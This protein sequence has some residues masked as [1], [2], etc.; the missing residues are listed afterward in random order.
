MSA[1]LYHVTRHIKGVH[2]AATSRRE[3]E[4]K[5]IFQSQLTQYDRCGRGM[6]IIGRCGCNDNN[7]D[8]VRV[9]S[10]FL[11]QKLS[12][13]SCQIRG[14]EPFFGKNATLFDTRSRSNPFVVGVYNSR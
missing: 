6:N 9:G 13:L 11:H 7:I 10:C 1:A 3:I 14:T 2:K 5:C 8:A 12:C 4:C